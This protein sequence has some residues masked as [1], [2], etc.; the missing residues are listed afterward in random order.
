MSTIM[1]YARGSICESFYV[2]KNDVSKKRSIIHVVIDTLRV[3][4]FDKKNN[5][6]Q[7]LTKT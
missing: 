3:D 5:K 4:L 2:K 1:W 6:P 7:F